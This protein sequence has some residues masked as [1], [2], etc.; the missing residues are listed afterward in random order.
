MQEINKERKKGKKELGVVALS[1]GQKEEKTV[2]KI[3]NVL[4]AQKK[5]QSISPQRVENHTRRLC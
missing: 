5:C 3:C 2:Y 1:R 4:V